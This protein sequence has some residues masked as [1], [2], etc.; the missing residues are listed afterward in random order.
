MII[1]GRYST[2]CKT[3]LALDS[4]PIERKVRIPRPVTFR[5]NH[6]VLALKLLSFTFGLLGH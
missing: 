5:E 1:R 3:W 4:A 2:L 6:Q